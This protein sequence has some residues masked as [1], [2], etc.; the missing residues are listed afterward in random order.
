MTRTPEVCLRGEC[1]QDCGICVNREGRSD[2]CLS[3]NGT[4]QS[5]S[6]TLPN[7]LHKYQNPIQNAYPWLPRPPQSRAAHFKRLYRK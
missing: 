6:E 1:G 7:L 3:P 2:Y 4:P 5:G